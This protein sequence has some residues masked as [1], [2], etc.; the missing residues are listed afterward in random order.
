MSAASQATPAT[1]PPPI[2]L[3]DAQCA[4]VAALLSL[5]RPSGGTS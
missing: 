3:T 2:T 4:R 5:G 1:S